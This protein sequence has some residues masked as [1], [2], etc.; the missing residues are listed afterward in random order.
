VLKVK[1]SSKTLSLL[2]TMRR[3]TPLLRRKKRKKN[4][5]SDSS[6]VWF[7]F[8]RIET[9]STENTRGEIR[10]ISRPTSP[11]GVATDFK[12]FG[13]SDAAFHPRVR[14]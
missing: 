1:I 11:R 8:A 3:N 9:T 14:D 13:H 12:T 6:C 5:S 4:G 10:T 2:F 7:R